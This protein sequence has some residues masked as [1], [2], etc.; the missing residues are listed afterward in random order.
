MFNWFNKK[1]ELKNTNSIM[2]STYIKKG[3]KVGSEIIVPPNFKCLIFNN[4]KYFLGL[5]SGKHKVSND[6]FESLILSQS[7]TKRKKHIKMVCHYINLSTQTLTIKYK[8]QNYTV[9]FKICDTL[10]F[11]NLLLLYTFKVDDSYTSN[12]LIDVFTEVLSWLNGDHTKIDAEFLKNYGIYIESF[13]QDNKKT[14]LFDNTK[15]LLIHT[16]SNKQENN[17]QVSQTSTTTQ[18]NKPNLET[19]SG[20]TAEQIPKIEFPQCPKCKNITK[21]NTTYCV[22]CGYKLE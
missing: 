8:K 21:F 16:S 11:A 19:N 17:N 12:T 3:I 22:R 14:S 9:K 4:G 13:I 15:D 20:G 7:K 18:S 1:V 6:K 2:S 5:D 10:D